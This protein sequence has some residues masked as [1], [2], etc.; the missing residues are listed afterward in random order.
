MSESWKTSS[1]GSLC[2][3][4][5]GGTPP[6][7]NP[8]FYGGDIPWATVRD[9]RQ[10]IIATTEYRITKDAVKSSATNVVPAGNVVIATRVGLGKVCLLAQDTAINQDLRG[11]VPRDSSILA[12]RFLYWWFKSIAE[13]IVAE[14]TGATVQGVKLPFVKSLQVPLPPIAEQRRIIGILDEILDGI[15]TAKANA[16]QNLRNAGALLESRLHSAFTEIREG[17]VESTVE[18][19]VDE[20]VLAKPF[21][22]NHGEIHPKKSDYTVSGV[23]FIMARDLH[24]GLVDT[25]NCIFISRKLAG[26]LRVG[27]AKDGDVLMSHKGTIGRTAILSTEDDYIMLTPQVTG[28]RIL[29]TSKLFN[30]FVRYYFMSPYFQRVMTVG[31]ADGSTRAYIGITKQLKLPFR[32]PAIG[33]QKRIASALDDLGEETERLSLL[34]ER[35]LSA[36]ETLKQSVLQHAFTGQL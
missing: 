35:K 3:I 34:Y 24:D 15:A 7:D 5:G 1:L 12:V 36:L 26:S 21:D 14:G 30:R 11:V 19:L 27:A 29:D 32:F 20:G 6:K 33:E 4:V 9:M 16:E 18:E 13:R 2:D 31:A 17:W 8:A 23:P 25:E 10:D 28:Y 22:G